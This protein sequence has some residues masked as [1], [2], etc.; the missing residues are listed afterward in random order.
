MTSS[1]PILVLDVGLSA[2]QNGDLTPQRDSAFVV[3]ISLLSAVNAC[4][5]KRWLTGDYYGAGLADTALRW[6]AFRL[7]AF[8]A[9]G[10]ATLKM[11]EWF[12]LSTTLAEG[13]WMPSVCLVP[14]LLSLMVLRDLS[15]ML[16]RAAID[17]LDDILDGISST[18]GSDTSSVG[19]TG[20]HEAIYLEEA[21]PVA[22]AGAKS[23]N[24]RYPNISVRREIYAIVIVLLLLLLLPL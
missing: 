18:D 21:A 22:T 23:R 19:E 13:R 3:W 1:W 7:V 14:A 12:G 15:G 10:L 9:H 6:A 16:M 11:A 24:R 8:P 20:D 17:V 5:S 2:W 4:L